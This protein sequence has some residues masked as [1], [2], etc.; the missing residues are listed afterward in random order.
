MAPTL[1]P[2]AWLKHDWLGGLGLFLAVILIYTPAWRAGFIWDDDINITANPCI[3][4]P[5]GLKEIW[6]TNSADICPLAL[7]TFWIEHLLWGLNP[8]PYHLVN[9]LLHAVC[10]V[11]LWRLLQSLRIPGAWLGA[12]LWGLHPLQVE[13]VAWISETKN[14]QSGLFYLLSVFFFVRWLKA[15]NR[16]NQTQK[17]W[18]YGWTLFFAALAM[19]S[20]TST[21]V[22]PAAFCLCA[23][24]LEGQWRWRNLIRVAPVFFMSVAAGVV[25]I[26]TRKLVGEEN[27]PWVRSWPERVAAS[28]DVIWFY[29][30][31]LV[32]PYPLIN[33]YPSW[34]IDATRLFS[35]LPLGAILVILIVLWSIRQ[36]WARICFFVFGYFLA[37]LFPVL[38]FVTMS[39]LAHC[40]VADH[41]QYLA[42]MGPM[43]LLG[44]VWVWLANRAIS[45]RPWLQLSLYAGVLLVFGILSWRRSWAFESEKS[46]WSDTVSKNPDCWIAH[47]NLGVILFQEGQ[48]DEAVAHYQKA[49]EIQPGY[50]EAY[51]NL[52]NALDQKRE[53]GEAIVQYQKALELYPGLAEAHANLGVALLQKGE[54]DEALA[55]F[56]QAAT[57]DPGNAKTCNDLG[58]A[59][60]QKGEVD[61]AIVQYRKALTIKSD[62][63]EAHNNLGWALLSK[64]QIGQA[65]GEFQKALQINP[66]YAGAYNNLGIALFNEGQPEAAISQF[67]EALRL[68][69]ND[70]ETKNNLARAEEII[71]QKAGLK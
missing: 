55:H 16:G 66:N 21:V 27:L 45:D 63:A 62:Y 54:V 42:A 8:L 10:V 49:L 43:A 36:P 22:L 18:N 25:S 47:N 12:A 6:T 44:A 41:L 71:R 35:Y 40:L 1:A 70:T 39:S 33:S 30:G 53:I 32:W 56:Q 26:L 23:W 14:T 52:G 2:P 59:F 57:L 58:W 67:Q 61:E 4:G 24:W 17:N 13:S 3:V 46:L 20:K 50:A 15:K 38:G 65:A 28:G 37:A 7:T 31:K 29:L 69:P 19:M 48:W 11:V 60:L 64:G 9:V 5:L 51:L 68:N 34:E